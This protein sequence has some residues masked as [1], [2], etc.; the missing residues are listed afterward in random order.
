VCAYEGDDHYKFPIYGNEMGKSETE[1][2][3]L[4]FGQFAS[5]N[6]EGMRPGYIRDNK[7]EL[8]C[9]V[10]KSTGYAKRQKGK[11][12]HW[13]WQYYEK[14]GQGDCN[15]EYTAS[16]LCACKREELE[17]EWKESPRTSF[18]GMTIGEQECSENRAG[19]WDVC[20]SYGMQAVSLPGGYQGTDKT[21]DAKVSPVPYSACRVDDESGYNVNDY[22]WCNYC[23]TPTRSEK[24]YDCLCGSGQS[25]KKGGYVDCPYRIHGQENRWPMDLMVP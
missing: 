19:C 16:Y 8:G 6:P 10:E 15:G 20:K 25:D 4:C 9:Y 11:A 12:Q 21:R 5:E 24:V 14:D 18:F 22:V 17:M 7:G 1:K 3:A 13:A 2:K 23:L